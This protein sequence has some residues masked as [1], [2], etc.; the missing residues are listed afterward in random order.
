MLCLLK[1]TCHTYQHLMF[2]LVISHDVPRQHNGVSEGA[3]TTEVD[4]VEPGG[5]VENEG[6]IVSDP[7]D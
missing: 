6:G 3:K 4:E 5:R 1:H 7:M 2:Y